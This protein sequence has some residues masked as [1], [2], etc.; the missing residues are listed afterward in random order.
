MHHMETINQFA[1]SFIK[2][3]WT[4]KQDSKSDFW[5][6]LRAPCSD[7]DGRQSA[8]STSNMRSLFPS[9]T[10]IIMHSCPSKCMSS[11]VLSTCLLLLRFLRRLSR[12]WILFVLIDAWNATAVDDAANALLLTQMT[13]KVTFK[14][15]C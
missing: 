12:K 15:A 10:C 9:L 5:P 14:T 6:L 1:V 11:L 3:G 7:R 2:V 8:F 13:L 4:S